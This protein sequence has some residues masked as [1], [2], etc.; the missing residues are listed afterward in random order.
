MHRA[1]FMANK[2]NNKAQYRTLTTVTTLSGI[3]YH[4]FDVH[5]GVQI[6]TV[7][8]RVYVRSST[9]HRK[10]NGCK[11]H[12]RSKWLIAGSYSVKKPAL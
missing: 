6:G 9:S 11:K 3:Q 4:P 5:I 2:K 10:H 1:A 8:S 12:R 7:A